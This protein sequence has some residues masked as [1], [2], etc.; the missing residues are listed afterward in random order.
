MAPAT[1]C[2]QSS[3][4]GSRHLKMNYTTSQLAMQLKERQCVGNSREA[5]LMELELEGL[6]LRLILHERKRLLQ[7]LPRSFR[8]LKLQRKPMEDSRRL[9]RCASLFAIGSTWVLCKGAL[10]QGTLPNTWVIWPVRALVH[11]D[12]V[13]A[14]RWV[15]AMGPGLPALISSIT[16]LQ[17]CKRTQSPFILCHLPG[18][19]YVSPETLRIKFS[20]CMHKLSSSAHTTLLLSNTESYF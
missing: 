3:G 7:A 8:S 11:S 1:G 16:W 6:K 14:L 13:W 9:W 5:C 2:F 15:T 19:G 10:F 4:E 17:C 20:P 12:K 18:K